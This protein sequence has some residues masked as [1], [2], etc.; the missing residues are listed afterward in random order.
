[1]KSK[2]DMMYDQAVGIRELIPE[3]V[4][5]KCTDSMACCPIEVFYFAEM[6]VY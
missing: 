4:N 6:N 1:M 3:V 5:G 2:E